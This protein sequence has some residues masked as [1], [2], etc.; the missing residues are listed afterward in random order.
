MKQKFK[1]YTIQFIKEIIPVIAGI[2]IALFIDN[3]NSQRKDKRYID[4]VFSTIDSEIKESREDILATIPQQ[5]SLIDSLDFYSTHKDVTI[6]HIVMRSKG[7]FIPRI[8]INAW[9]A[10]S[11]SKID[12]IDYTKVASLSNI[13]EL[14]GTLSEKTQFL[15]SFLYTNINATDHNTKQTLKM[16]LL[17]ILQT[18]KTIEQ[19]IKLFE[20][21]NAG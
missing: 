2:L 16:I 3:W 8:R 13:E 19:N 10:V 14:K 1:H 4:Q 21:E 20:K 7:I 17:D 18:E 11:S 9:K 15:M 12:L 6:Q 5:E